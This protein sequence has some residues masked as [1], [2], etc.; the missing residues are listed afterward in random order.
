MIVYYHMKA[1]YMYVHNI[2][3]LYKNTTAEKISLIVN[4]ALDRE[5]N[6]VR[7]LFVSFMTRPY[8]ETGFLTFNKN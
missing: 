3:V 7:K 1:T 4:L 6:L 2:E 5:L 8:Y